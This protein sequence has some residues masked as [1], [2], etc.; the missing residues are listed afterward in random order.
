MDIVPGLCWQEA[1]EKDNDVMVNPDH[2]VKLKHPFLVAGYEKFKN[3]ISDQKLKDITERITSY[4]TSRSEQDAASLDYKVPNPAHLD[5]LFN[6]H[7][8]KTIDK[9]VEFMLKQY[10]KVEYLESLK[11]KDIPCTCKGECVAGAKQIL[12]I[13]ANTKKIIV[14]N[15][16]LRT[17]F[18]AYKRQLKQVPSPEESTVQRFQK[19]CDR[20]FDTYLEPHLKTFD[21]SFGAWFNH[22]P[23]KKQMDILKV[24]PIEMLESLKKTSTIPHDL[25]D[26][27]KETAPAYETLT[28]EE[29]ITYGLFCKR[30][31]Q[32]DG[33]KNRAIANISTLVKYIMG[34]ICWKLEEIFTLHAPGYCG[35]K[36]WEKLE[37]WLDQEYAQG[38]TTVLQGDGSGFDLSQHVEM[39]Y[40]DRKIYNYLVENS[41]VKHVDSRIFQLAA[42][43]L[44]KKLDAKIFER[45]GTT[46][47]A[48]AEI[49]GTVFSGSS[50]TT[51][52]NTLRMSLYNMFTLECNSQK[53][54][55]Y[56]EDFVH[57]AKGDDFM[58]LVRDPTLHYDEIYSE[59]WVS[60][61][62]ADDRGLCFRGYGLG[63]ILK[64]LLIGGFETIDFCSTTVIPYCNHTRFKMARKVDR[65]IS[66]GHFSRAA[67]TMKPGELKQYYL[68]LA[69]S[70]RTSM[71]NM[72]F[73]S[74]YA[75]AM[76]FH[77]SLIPST[78]KRVGSGLQRYHIFTEN[79]QVV[80]DISSWDSKILEYGYSIF[81]RLKYNKS[82]K[83]I[84]ASDVYDHLLNH[85]HITKTMIEYHANF[86]KYGGYYDIMSDMVKSE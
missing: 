80:E 16:C 85:Y 6:R 72:P 28:E 78:S 10:L 50:D 82:A 13:G 21:Y 53:Q 51:L 33:G 61:K 9:Q 39:K 8:L 86:L 70:I 37:D 12:P 79:E 3:G 26:K 71:P 19:Y 18:A 4:A 67:L 68:D 47:L 24:L 52:M 29:L 57:L 27:F 40:I 22:N 36:S 34:S 75:A 81:Q 48:S 11:I 23:A 54:L 74:Q 5:C 66:L 43:T 38:F 32:E 56:G 17:L 15:S 41:K 49:L 45:S 30:E 55:I 84:P 35:N 83:Q 65:M 46:R 1:M 25:L 7:N 63:Q 58:V 14:Y 60:K 62:A 20:Y 64:F 44:F 2:I 73:Y 76:E 31:K 77:A 42:T 69:Q 59:F